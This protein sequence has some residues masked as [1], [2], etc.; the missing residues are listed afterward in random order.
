[1]EPDRGQIRIAAEQVL[2]LLL[3]WI[4][5]TGAPHLRRERAMELPALDLM[6]LDHLGHGLAVDVDRTR[7]AAK[8]CP[9]V[10]T[11]HDLGA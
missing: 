5:E 3:V 1:V 4:E 9:A 11:A 6:G 2:D 8:R 10:E 7:D